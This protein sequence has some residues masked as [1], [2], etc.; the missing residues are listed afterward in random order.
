LAVSLGI[1]LVIACAACGDGNEP[2]AQACDFGTACRDSDCDTLCDLDEG[3][4]QQR[5][6]DD[7]GIPDYLDDDADDDGISDLEEAGDEDPKTPPYDRNLDGVADYLDPDYPLGAGR[8]DPD[9][10]SAFDASVIVPEDASVLDGS[11]HYAHD[12]GN[13]RPELCPSDAV[14]PPLCLSSEADLCDGLDN[15]CDGTVDGDEICGCDRGAVRACFIGPP[16]R[17]NVGA[18][19]SGT[20]VCEGEEFTKWSPCQ[21]GIAPSQEICDGLDNDCN[22]CSDEL[23]DCVPAL[24][25]P[26]PGDPRTPDAKPFAPYV[27]DASKFYQGLG[28]KAVKSYRWQIE[29]S[30]CDRM[31]GALDGSAT[32]QSGKLSYRLEDDRSAKATAHFSLS[33]S[34]IVTLIITT[35]DGEQRCS[36]PL[37]VRAP[38]LRVELCWDKT[39]PVAHGANQ[40]VDL[41]LHLGRRAATST[42]GSDQDCYWETCRGYETP[43]SFANT[44]PLSSC[45]GE[46]AQNYAAYSALGY[47]PNPR[48]DA[49]NRLDEASAARYI[50]ENINLDA[51]QNG[52]ELR[53]MVHYNTNLPADEAEPGSLPL[54][55]IATHPLVNVYCNGELHGSFGGDPV[56]L[57]DSEELEGFTTPGQ[58]WRVLD[59]TTWTDG[60]TVSGLQ[61]PAP[62]G[63]YWVSE[64]EAHYGP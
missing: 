18:C 30:P 42:W 39:G 47:C 4:A 21:G 61:A 45:S 11:G 59:V 54:P 31:F 16:G 43:W 58:M 53:V 52:D 36:W 38:G 57:G 6:T 62:S 13:V 17:R 51:P 26:G 49:D 37:H 12:G 8:H 5:D 14:A 22:G 19:A 33:G 32:A 20:Q 10:G 24:S 3:A 46:G 40:A 25:C 64:W 1:S 41:D 2:E 60:C 9:A 29:G 7:D 63:G 27:L 50:T 35:D 34:Y 23:S 55:A 48:L 15:D 28:V 56:I 44:T